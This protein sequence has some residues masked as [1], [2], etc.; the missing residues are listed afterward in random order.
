M[1]EKQ[2]RLMDQPESAGKIPG[3][4]EFFK[5][6][7]N[8]DEMKLPLEE[9]K[10]F[11]EFFTRELKAGARP[12]YLPDEDKIAVCGAD[13]RLM[14]FDNVNDAKRF[15]IKGRKFSLKGLLG[16]K[17]LGEEFS[18]GSLVIF[19]L[20]PQDYHRF[21]FPVSGQISSITD[22][23]GHLY[24]VNP[25][26]VNSRYCNVFTQN[27]RAVALIETAQFGKKTIAF[28]GDL[29]DNSRESLE[30]LVCMGQS[31]GCTPSF[32]AQ[33]QLSRRMSIVSVED[34]S[35]EKCKESVNL[36]M[37]HRFAER[38]GPAEDGQQDNDSAS[39]TSESEED[40]Y[41]EGASNKTIAFDGDLLDNSRE[42]LETL[43]CMGQ[44]LGCTPSFLAQRQLSRRMSIV[45]VEDGSKEKCKESVNLVMTHRFAER[46]GPAEDGQQDNDSA[47]STSESEE[48]P[49][50]EG[51]SN[52]DNNQ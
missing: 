9:Y 20:A 45:S 7:I 31:L 2:G 50:Q 10:T 38:D 21:H 41:Q 34:G 42:S 13:A 24:T 11:N 25:I 32:L 44:S 37:T 1:S 47:S 40:P 14:A 5:D 17:G 12:I 43:V 16:S 15:W 8:I 48:D 22:I 51:A 23:P 28:D 18:G 35:K 46:D 19:R 26:A 33:R 29:L 30:T 39:S 49:Y 6:N 27:K 3:F 36:V 52:V 4:V